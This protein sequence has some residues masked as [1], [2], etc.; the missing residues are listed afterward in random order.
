MVYLQPALDHSQDSKSSDKNRG[1]FLCFHGCLRKGSGTHLEAALWH[2]PHIQD[3][4]RRIH[5]PDRLIRRSPFLA[6]SG[7]KRGGV[8]ILGVILR[9]GK[10]IYPKFGVQ[11][12]RTP[13]TS[14]SAAG[15]CDHHSP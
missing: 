7:P 11:H 6:L 1:R 3:E 12:Q 13:L 14:P 9:H 4:G 2:S 5:K 8:S 15:I 10:I